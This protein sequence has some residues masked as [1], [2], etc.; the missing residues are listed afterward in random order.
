[1]EGTM[2]LDPRTLIVASLLSAALLG[3]ISL[4]FATMRGSSRVI[5]A[6]GKAMLLLAAGLLGLALRGVIPD[7]MSIAVGNTVIVAALVLALRSL[8]GFLGS[9]LRD[10]AGWRG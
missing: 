4:A 10:V 9:P 7:W 3:A 2:E 8:R 6:W 1:M 5:G